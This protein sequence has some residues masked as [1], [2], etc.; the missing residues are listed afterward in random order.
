MGTV[1]GPTF[2]LAGDVFNVAAGVQNKFNPQT[3]NAKERAGVRAVAS[4][5]P[6][7]GQIRSVR[8]GVTDAVAGEVQGQSGGGF[9]SFGSFDSGF[10]T[11]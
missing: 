4:R 7:L 5:T 6:I 2:G 1:F 8:E 11:F 10:D 3:T 9:G